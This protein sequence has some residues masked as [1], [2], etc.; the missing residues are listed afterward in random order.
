MLMQVMLPSYSHFKHCS[1][2]L[3]DGFIMVSCPTQL[4]KDHSRDNIFLQI[5]WPNQQWV[6]LSQV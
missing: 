1:H 4:V 3:L 6:E 2:S 5:W